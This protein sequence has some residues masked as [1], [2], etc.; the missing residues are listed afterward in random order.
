MKRLAAGAA[1]AILL[2]IGYPAIHATSAAATL[3]GVVATPIPGFNETGDPRSVNDQGTIIGVNYG[4]SGPTPTRVAVVAVRRASGYSVQQ[5]QAPAGWAGFVEA[6]QINASG[7][8]LG[9]AGGVYVWTPDRNRR[10]GPPTFITSAPYPMGLSDTGVVLVDN[11][12]GMPAEWV[13]GGSGYTRRPVPAGALAINGAA[14]LAGDVQL[15]LAAG[16]GVAF[17]TWTPSPTGYSKALIPGSVAV[18]HQGCQVRTVNDSGDVL[19]VCSEGISVEYF[20]TKNGY[21]N[22]G[23][24]GFAQQADIST[25]GFVSGTDTPGN[26]G[27]SVGAG[28]WLPP[29]AG[30][31]FV[32]LPLPAGTAPG[33]SSFG[34]GISPNAKYV[35]GDV[36][37]QTVVWTGVDALGR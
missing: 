32:Y 29:S 15:P 7:V 1:A 33:T 22:L 2:S 26:G 6:D 30:N 8:I 20:R 17:A 36:G 25:S 31:G 27:S 9:T 5:L 28:V 14:V 3:S 10:Y 34:G 24:G 16:G 21:T 18:S 35:V 19:G 11:A 4:F 23:A 13:P 12:S 37:S